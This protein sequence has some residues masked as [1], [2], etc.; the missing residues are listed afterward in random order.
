MDLTPLGSEMSTNSLFELLTVYT[1]VPARVLATCSE[2]NPAATACFGCEIEANGRGGGC[3]GRTRLF[4]GGQRAAARVPASR[5]V[6]SKRAA[7]SAPR[8]R[9]CWWM[10][11]ESESSGFVGPTKGSG[12]WGSMW[13]LD[14]APKEKRNSS[15]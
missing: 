2:L 1:A 7:M 15:E 9:Q 8:R 14:L 12:F 4:G 6:S 10:K 13:I 11:V 5:L 3:A